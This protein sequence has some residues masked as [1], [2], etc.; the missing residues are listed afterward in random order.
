MD[1][2]AYAAVNGLRMYYEVHGS[3]EP[4]VLVH[5]GMLTIETT[6]G[7]LIGPL[8]TR[9]RII[10]VE[11]QGHGHTADIDRT[12]SIAAHAADIVALLDHLRLERVDLLGFSLGGLVG[13][14]LAVNHPSRLGRLV[15]ASAHVRPDGYHAE[16]FDEELFKTSSRV[17]TPADFQ[18][19]VDAYRSVA[20]DPDH[21]PEFMAKQSAQVAAFRGW[22]DE[23]LHAISSPTLLLIGDEAFVRIEHGAEMLE[24]IPGSQLAVL[25]GATHMAVMQRTEQVLAMVAPLLAGA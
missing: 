11:L 8:A 9:R 6:F 1:E 7:A 22:T 15:A 24:L 5:G 21:F 18:A 23:Q 17:P 10:A 3:G 25:P 20:P 19:M 14:E 2:G 12:P 16:I 13:F 4:L